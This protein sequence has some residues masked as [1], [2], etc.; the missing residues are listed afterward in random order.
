MNSNCRSV[1]DAPCLRRQATATPTEPPQEEVP[2]PADD[3]ESD[4]FPEDETPEDDDDEDDDDED[5][6]YEEEYRVSRAGPLNTPAPEDFKLVF[7]NESPPCVCLTS[8]VLLRSRARRKRTTTMTR[9]PCRP[10]T[11]KRRNLSTVRAL[12]AE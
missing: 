1:C 3:N 9:E 2:E 4:Q 7:A 11:Q 12:K 10:T 8:R 6:P 5:E